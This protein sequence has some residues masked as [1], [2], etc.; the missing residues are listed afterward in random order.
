MIKIAGQI[1][2]ILF[3]V[4]AARAQEPAA[5]QAL[6]DLMESLGSEPDEN[7]DFQEILDDLAYV[8]QHPLLVNSATKEEFLRLHFLSEIQ[9]DNLIEF[10]TKTGQIYSLYEM[11]AIEGYN[12]DLLTKLEPF[13]S[14]EFQGNEYKTKKSDN[15]LF[16]RSTRSFSNS[17]GG[18]KNP[19]YEGS[20]ERYYLRFKHTST[21]FEYGMVA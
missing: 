20:M 3:V 7:I 18:V 8:S 10:R 14:F 11:A 6:E 21:D 2:L 1:I 19:D 17:E 15:D 9:I 16:V 13:I 12:P 4:F 5:Q